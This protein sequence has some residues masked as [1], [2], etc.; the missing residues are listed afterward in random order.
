MPDGSIY[1]DGKIQLVGHGRLAIEDLG[2][3]PGVS[4]RLDKVHSQ[5]QMVDE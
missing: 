2:M 4:N 5:P 1:R 3:D